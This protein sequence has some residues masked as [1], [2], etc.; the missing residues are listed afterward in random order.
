[1]QVWNLK[2][3]KLHL[4]LLWVRTDLSSVMQYTEN[5]LFLFLLIVIFTGWI[6]WIIKTVTE[7]SVKIIFIFKH[8]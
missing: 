2:T 4:L 8:I 6:R 5:I 1:M 7:V 3:V